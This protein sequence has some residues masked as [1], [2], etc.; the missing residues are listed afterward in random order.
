MVGLPSAGLHTN[1]YSLA[2]SI[3]FERLGL[4][5]EIEAAELNGTIGA[6]ALAPSPLLSAPACKRS[7]RRIIKGAVRTSR[8]A[9]L[10]DNIPRILP[11]DTSAR[12][13]RGSWEVPWLFSFLQEA[14][15]RR[16]EHVPHVQYGDRH[17]RRRCRGRSRAPCCRTI[18]R[19]V[20][21]ARVMGESSR[22]M[23]RLSTQ[24][25]DP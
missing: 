18:R 21:G 3:L 16:V 23:G 13:Q 12:I 6:S 1:G 20:T 24:I 7:W 8:E 2:R 4:R 15:T 9:E 19:Q 10:P 5:V 17:G 22:A 11:A 14:G 25:P